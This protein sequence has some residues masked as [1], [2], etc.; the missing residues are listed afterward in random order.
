MLVIVLI[1]CGMTV[2]GITRYLDDRHA[3]QAAAAALFTVAANEPKEDDME[4]TIPVVPRSGTSSIK[5]R[6]DMNELPGNDTTADT[7][8][9]EEE[10]EE[11]QNDEEQK[12]DT[13]D[14]VAVVAY[15]VSITG[16]GD[17]PLLDGAAV[18]KRSI[19]LA[20]YHGQTGNNRRRYGS[21]MYA[22]VHPSAESC[23]RELE[24]VGYEVL[25]RDTFVRVEDI[26]G[27]FL[28]EKIETN[29]CCG[30][31]ELIKLEAFTMT[32][33]PIVVHMDLDTI[34]LK[35][36]DDVF[37]LMLGH[38]PDR[39]EQPQSDV[40]R[41]KG[42]GVAVMWNELAIPDRI[43][44]FFTR[45]YNMAHPSM[46]YKPVQGGLL[47]LRPSLDTYEEFRRIIQK[48][49]FREGRG[50]GGK[51]GP[52]YGSMTFQGI[53]PYY[54][55]VLH[56]ESAVEL[57]RC[58]Y[59]QMC[60]NPR[61]EPTIDD[62]VHGKCKTG[63]ADCEDCRSLPLEEVHTAHFTL[64]QKPWNCVPND[65]DRIQERLCRK[66]HHEWF[67]VRSDL[68]ASWGRT[69]IGS[70]SYQSDHFFGFCDSGFSTNYQRIVPP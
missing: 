12:A 55:D 21:K 25:V 10:E 50:W 65:G 13:S 42:H 43:D 58:I 14:V 63:E 6:G 69:A 24:S 26:E 52:F 39:P 23:G 18:L 64:C 66:L 68:E 8:E 40:T 61:D 62:V 11:Q 7:D 27:D 34:V 41:P 3:E 22:I 59:N 54:Y 17:D 47:V 9:Q 33:H 30:E 19:E 48:G 36:F 37:D 15:A 29:G 2:L 49:D 51:V 57:N 38:A 53:V 70:G 16:C 56:P 20:S 45:D 46:R 67:R 28:R 44:A 1:V 5:D 35:P 4:G 60:D 32:D 31:K